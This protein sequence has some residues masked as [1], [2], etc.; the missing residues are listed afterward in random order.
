MRLVLRRGE[1]AED[2]H[3]EELV[4]RIDRRV[5]EGPAEGLPSPPSP[6]LVA[7]QGVRTRRRG[8]E[9]WTVAGDKRRGPRVVGV[10]ADR[11]VDVF[12]LF[13]TGFSSWSRR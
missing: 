4:V 5:Q 3:C 13:L 1:R 6:L 11:D 2:G 8:H 12:F 7:S 10:V 9:D